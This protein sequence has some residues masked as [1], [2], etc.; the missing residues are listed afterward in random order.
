MAAETNQYKKPEPIDHLFGGL[1]RYSVVP[2]MVIQA[3]GFVSIISGNSN[4]GWKEG[5]LMDSG[6]KRLREM[7]VRLKDDRSLAN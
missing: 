2:P 1:Q 7:E 6:L 4:Y 5:G 3:E